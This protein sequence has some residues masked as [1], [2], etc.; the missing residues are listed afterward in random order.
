MNA[1]VEIVIPLIEKM[2][3]T[4]KELNYFNK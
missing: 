3:Q 2:E 4:K 1:V